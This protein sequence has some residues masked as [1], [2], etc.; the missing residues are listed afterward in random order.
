MSPTA[1]AAIV[2]IGMFLGDVNLS[3]TGGF[4]FVIGGALFV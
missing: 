1:G 4:L 3:I 2:L